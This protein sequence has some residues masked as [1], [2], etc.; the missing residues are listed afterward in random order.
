M[1]IH[2]NTDNTKKIRRNYMNSNDELSR[3]VSATELALMLGIARSGIFNL[4]K[5]GK[6]PHGVKIGRNRRWNVQ[7]VKEWLKHQNENVQ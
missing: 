6:F 3:Y 4:M 7:E 2:N 1:T 5:Q